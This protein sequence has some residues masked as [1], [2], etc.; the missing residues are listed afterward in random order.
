MRKMMVLLL[1][2][3]ITFTSASVALGSA[4][5]KPKDDLIEL[6]DEFTNKDSLSNW[7]LHHEVEGWPSQVEVLDINKSKPGAL[8]LI[9]KTG[10]WYGDFR[11]VYAFKEINGDF[12]VTTRLKVSGKQ[13]ERPT[14]IFELAGLLVRQPKNTT[15]SNWK[16]EQENWIYLNYGTPDTANELV[17]DSKINLKSQFT[18]TITPVATDWIQLKIAKVGPWFFQFYKFDHDDNWT[19]HRRV[20]LPELPKTLQVGINAHGNTV[21]SFSTD[22]KTFNETVYNS[23]EDHADLDV[24]FDFVRFQRPVVTDELKAKILKGEALDRE[25]VDALS[26]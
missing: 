12:I 18:Y 7:K 14:G 17:L 15:A 2:T 8:H 22:A 9:P 10:T 6:S 5:S 3:C 24:E 16:P 26:H 25:I 19:L 1:T 11:G 20:N 13:S 21:K 23:K 4:E